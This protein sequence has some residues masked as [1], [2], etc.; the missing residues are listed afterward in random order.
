VSQR[1]IV[2]GQFM[3]YCELLGM[4]QLCSFLDFE[5]SRFRGEL[6]SQGKGGDDVSIRAS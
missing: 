4:R 3:K 2:S 1:G 5:V 6:R